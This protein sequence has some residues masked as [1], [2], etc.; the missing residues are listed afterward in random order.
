MKRGGVLTAAD[1]AALNR[2]PPQIDPDDLTRCF[3]LTPA[4][5]AKV[6]DRRYGTAAQLAAGLQI[7]AL[8]L[9]G[10]VPADLSA[11]PT[12]VLRYVANQ[13]GASPS[14]LA[15]YTT[16]RA[17]LAEH[18]TIVENHVGFRRAGYA[19]TAVSPTNPSPRRC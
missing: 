10:F 8:R 7:G 17:T 11:A 2:F 1:R 19:V 5:F 9:L 18:L 14:D 12:E 15:K 6:I 3:T 13:V 4:D 16:R